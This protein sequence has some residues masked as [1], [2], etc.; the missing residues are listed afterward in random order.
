MPS[1]GWRFL[2]WGHGGHAKVVSD[3]IGLNDH[4]IAGHVTEEPTEA[5]GDPAT[6]ILGAWYGQDWFLDRLASGSGYP[7]GVD[8]VALG[9]GSNS[10]RIRLLRALRQ[11]PVPALVHPRAVVCSDA[12]LGRGTVVMAGAVI[13]AAAEIGQATIVNTG[14]II[15][16]DCSLGEAV[17]VSPGAVLAGR[18]RVGDRS[19]I[20]A[21]ATVIDGVQIAADVVVGAGAVVIRNVAAG[22]VVVGVP[23]RPLLKPR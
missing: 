8:A 2:V 14:S 21:G 9:I 6:G 12:M 1:R 15:E 20:G 22:E 23:A 10:V 13:N 18:V 3:I 11:L 5:G 19:W 16:H 4:T 17:H 7:S